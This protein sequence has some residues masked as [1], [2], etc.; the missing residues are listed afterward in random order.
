M[1]IRERGYVEFRV[2]PD[3]LFEFEGLPEVCNLRASLI[4]VDG[5][6]YLFSTEY[7]S[8]GDAS[9]RIVVDSGVPVAGDALDEARE[10]YRRMT[11]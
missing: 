10:L 6:E 11:E 3:V 8:L 4:P 2:H 7:V 1:K 9:R 5:H